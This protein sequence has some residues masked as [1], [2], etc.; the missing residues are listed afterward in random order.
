MIY[1]SI[2]SADAQSPT[3]ACHT[4]YIQSRLQEHSLL[5]LLCNYLWKWVAPKKGNTRGQQQIPFLKAI[6]STRPNR[7]NSVASDSNW[8]NW[9]QMQFICIFVWYGNGSKLEMSCQD[10]IFIFHLAE[11]KGAVSDLFLELFFILIVDIKTLFRGWK[12]LES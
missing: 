9:K 5:D 2:I 11:V 8:T 1:S 10:A 4:P 7:E 6:C 12:T 3:P